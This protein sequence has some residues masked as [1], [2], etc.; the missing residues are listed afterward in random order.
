MYS[1]YLEII[2][3]KGYVGG[4]GILSVEGFELMLQLKQAVEL[5]L[6]KTNPEILYFKDFG[7]CCL[8]R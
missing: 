4:Y 7:V 1:F 6:N 3:C 5:G 8:F 2:D